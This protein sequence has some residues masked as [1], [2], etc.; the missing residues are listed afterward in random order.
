MTAPPSQPPISLTPIRTSP[1]ADARG[2]LWAD[3][4][5]A[6]EPRVYQ[7]GSGT[8]RESGEFVLCWLHHAV[9]GHDNP[10]LD[11]SVFLA[12]K[13]G[14]PV[15]AY[16]GLGGRHRYNSDRHHVFILE[17]ARDAARELRERG[18]S[19]V[20]HLPTDPTVASPLTDLAARAAAV[21]TEDFPAPPFP[22][23]TA[24]LAERSA[25][26]VFVVDAAC[27]MP[28]RS[29][30][31]RF[32]RAF[33]FRDAAK[34]AW[35]REMA[36]D[37][38]DIRPRVEPFPASGASLGFEPFDLD[39]ADFGAAA[40]A[41]DIDHSVP[42]VGR[43]RGGSDA[44]YERWRVFRDRALSRYDKRRNDA[45]DMDA[46]SCLSPYLHHGHVSPFRIAREAR[47][48]GGAGAE[49]FLDELLVWRELAFNFCANTPSHQLDTL[50]AVPS[51]ARD[52]LEQHA[53]DQRQQLLSWESLAR[54]R[55][56]SP[57]WDEAQRSLLVNGELHNNVRMTWGKAVLEWTRGPRDALSKIIDLNHRFA[58][59]G[60]DPNSYGGLL[61]CLGQFDRPFK[62]DRPVTG[63]VR[64]RSPEVHAERLKPAEYRAAILSRVAHEPRRVA[65][66]GG[67]I[68]GL[69]CAR[70]LADQLCDVTV[71]DKGREPGGRL[72]TRT[73]DVGGATVTFDHGCPAFDVTDARFGRAVR[74]WIED[75]VC[76]AWRP[77]DADG[78]P[79]VVGLP[80]SQSIARHLAT[81]LDVR[82]STGVTGLTRDGRGWTVGYESSH[83]GAAGSE[84]FDAVVLAMAPEQASRLL[85]A[86]LD[87]HAASPSNAINAVNAIGSHTQWVLMLALSTVLDDL[88]SLQQI[89]GHGALELCIREDQKPGRRV[90]S[91][92]STLVFHATA[93]WSADRY[94]TPRDDIASQLRPAA[95]GWLAGRVG[96]DLT[97]DAVVFERAHRWGLARPMTPG[98]DRVVEA[99]DGT[100][101]IAG[102]GFGGS[103]VE[104]AFLSGQAVAGRVLAGRARRSTT[105]AG[106]FEGAAG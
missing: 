15:L 24:R 58:L 48:R 35:A 100:L 76:A 65:V 40:A 80:T 54:G 103:G 38:E 91:G 81:D 93:A 9:R 36:L 19:S 53:A 63:T 46:V 89:E 74:S 50:H 98:G 26:A 70:T 84:S 92:V 28:L 75:G 101:V 51:W 69:V 13:L 45:A 18:I 87:P 56:G 22:R 67:G 95:L 64:E 31:T 68:T 49:K 106:L 94:D 12:N 90:P 16:Q 55:S 30:D 34:E 42:P 4:P 71:F 62:P 33:K 37:H 82:S 29:T 1:S 59:D 85:P 57:L 27:V 3:V 39:A 72:S 86:R 78:P 17:G 32:T 61:W 60:C 97:E 44:G 14:L 43:V 10:A 99:A 6:L 83:D 2:D 21:V 79:L 20:F 8:V 7:L 88:P 47:E 5:A 73:A 105:D 104:A 52:S 11:A 25:A 41:C 96:R 23:W 102:D 66:V 77:E